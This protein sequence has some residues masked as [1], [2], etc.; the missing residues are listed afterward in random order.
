MIPVKS[1]SV[2]ED[3]EN[4]IQIRLRPKLGCAEEAIYNKLSERY[5]E[6]KQLYCFLNTHANCLLLQFTIILEHVVNDLMVLTSH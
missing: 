6:P 3:F 4:L 2:L 1:D 5:T